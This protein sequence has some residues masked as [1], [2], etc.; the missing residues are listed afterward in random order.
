[1][2]KHGLV[3]PAYTGILECTTVYTNNVHATERRIR[4]VLAK[5]K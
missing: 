3:P 1:M 4:D 5:R 2:I